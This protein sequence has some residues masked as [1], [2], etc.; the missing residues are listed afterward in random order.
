MSDLHMLR[1]KLKKQPHRGRTY[2]QDINTSV[3][4][5]IIN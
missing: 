2:M 5:Q 4:L 1:N 3:T